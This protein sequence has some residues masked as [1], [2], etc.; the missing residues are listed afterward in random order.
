MHIYISRGLILEQ[1]TPIQQLLMLY[2]PIE[3]SCNYKIKLC[4]S[5]CFLLSLSLNVQMLWF[6]VT[7][8]FSLAVFLVETLFRVAAKK[9]F[10]LIWRFPEFLQGAKLDSYQAKTV[11]FFVMY[12]VFFS[13]SILKMDWQEQLFCN[14]LA[15]R[16][17]A[18]CGTW[19]A[20]ERRIKRLLKKCTP[21]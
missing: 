7:Q 17:P 18:F 10:L 15:L 4:F 9:I 16:L 2:G 8:F 14:S 13:L 12:P 19:T 20:R 21:F 1:K 6:S 11:S 5:K 3:K